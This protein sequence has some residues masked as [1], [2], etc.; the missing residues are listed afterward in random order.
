VATFGTYPAPPAGNPDFVP[1][2]VIQSDEHDG[3]FGALATHLNSAFVAD[4]VTAD[5]ALSGPKIADNTIVP[6]Q[7]SRKADPGGAAV[8]QDNLATLSVG[9]AEMIDLSVT[10]AKIALLAVGDAQISDVDGTKIA[11]ASIPASALDPS[12][13]FP[14]TVTNEIIQFPFAGASVALAAANVEPVNITVTGVGGA[15]VYTDPADWSFLAPNFIV[16]NGAGTIPTVTNIEVDYTAAA[17]APPPGSVTSV[18]IQ[19]DT[20]EDVDINSAAGIQLSK[21]ATDPLAR[22][23]HTGTQLSGTISDFAAG[24]QGVVVGGEVTGTV[25]NQSIAAGVVGTPEQAILPAGLIKRT[26]T[27]LASTATVWQDIR[28]PVTAK[29]DGGMTLHNTGN[30]VGFVAPVSGWYNVNVTA[31]ATAASIQANACTE[32]GVRI[33]TNSSHTGGLTQLSGET[34]GVNG[35]AQTLRPRV[36]CSDVVPLNAGE[37]VDGQFISDVN[38]VVPDADCTMSISFSGRL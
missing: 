7:L 22:A 35:A 34:V 21:L 31:I 23:N 28:F 4:D 14:I 8:L 20:I 6:L 9:T 13:Q 15:P 33:S 26:G 16:H 19:D 29:L 25:G 17:S 27:G 32:F 12:I 30:V 11:A 37:W 3:N 2:S 38:G 5:G 10:T 18:T 24:V 36:A 1:G